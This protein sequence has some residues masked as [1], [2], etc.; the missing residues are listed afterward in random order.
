MQTST[1]TVQVFTGC[2]ANNSPTYSTRT[3]SV[4]QGTEEAERL[5]FEQAA[6][7]DGATCKIGSGSGFANL[8]NE[9]RD[10]A[11]SLMNATE[12]TINVVG[13]GFNALQ[14][15]GILSEGNWQYLPPNVSLKS[16][17]IAQLATGSILDATVTV[18]TETPQT[19]TALSQ[20]INTEI[21]NLNTAIQTAINN[22]VTARNQEINS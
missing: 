8:L 16:G 7:A 15:D 20:Q 19:G 11:S 18:A 21:S 14:D 22:A 10:I 12:Q 4:I 6:I 2:D 9:V 1:I 5:K 17:I 3:V 13:K